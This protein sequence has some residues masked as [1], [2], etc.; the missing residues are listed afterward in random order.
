MSKKEVEQTQPTR[1]RPEEV[2]ASINSNE[3]TQASELQRRRTLIAALAA[4]PVVLTLTSRSIFAAQPTCS[5]VH[6]INLNGA[7]SHHPGVQIN[8]DDINRCKT[9]L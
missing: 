1:E 3:E 6:S 8:N 7:A 2:V 4:L 5:V 9:R